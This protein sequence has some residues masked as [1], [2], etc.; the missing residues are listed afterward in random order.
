MP[1]FLTGTT[2][3]H[4]RQDIAYTCIDIVCSKIASFAPI[5]LV[6]QKEFLAKVFGSPVVL[7]TMT[8][9]VWDLFA[10][11]RIDLSSSVRRVAIWR[12]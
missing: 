2:Q 6:A 10:D 5:G 7:H 1:S 9:L 12:N 4:E 11:L 3:I 8:F